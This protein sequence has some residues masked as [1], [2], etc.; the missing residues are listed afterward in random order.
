MRLGEALDRLAAMD[1]Q[2][3][4]GFSSPSA[5]EL[6]RCERG[7][8]WAGDSR[9]LA[10]RLLRKG[11]RG[12]P[13]IRGALMGGVMLWSMAEL[14]ATWA[15]PETESELIAAARGKTVRQMRAWLA[16]RR[17]A[18]RD[19]PL[20]SEDEEDFG[21]L[22]LAVGFAEVAVVEATRA[23]VEALDGELVTD[24]RLLEAM[25][26]E[27]ES[28]L[29]G[30]EGGRPRCKDEDED[31]ELQ[32][33]SAAPGRECRARE[34]ERAEARIPVVATL[35]VW[36]EEAP[37]PSTP[38]ELDAEIRRC[39]GMLARRDLEMGRLCRVLLGRRGWET[40]GYATAAQY[41]RERV[42]V[43]LSSL[44]HRCALARCADRL[45]SLGAALEGGVLGYEAARLVGR[46]A[47]PQ[48]VDA[49]VERATVRTIKHLREE[50]AAVELQ[51][52]LGE[53]GPLVP[54]D[55]GQLQEVAAFERAAL[56][57][58]VFKEVLAAKPPGRQIS[59]RAGSDRELRLRVSSGLR[60]YFCR[61]R[62]R[63]ERVAPPEASFIGFLGLAVWDAWLP[64]VRGTVGRWLGIHLRDRYRCCSPVCTRRDVT[65]H[66]LQ[67][68]SHGGGDEDENVA[69]LCSWCHLEGIHQGRLRASPPASNI[70][71]V[72]G[73]VPIMRVDGRVRRLLEGADA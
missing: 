15:T 7:V 38:R 10:S 60:A 37:L 13:G 58:E 12:L 53:V 25:L 1:G 48:T 17:G 35:G 46:V 54:P 33:G 27:G 28:A 61:L 11:G 14:L 43:S 42:G 26:A 30:L 41:A 16:T 47:A 19:E 36:E 73:R 72:I 63:F 40:L 49:W 44:R 2:A 21:V 70:G 18:D 34:E 68:R 31:G 22:R 4:L 57:G 3:E 45:P 65:A 32:D 23:V 9:R 29:L 51:E 52:R 20:E 50:V 71:W 8:R 66:H 59:V 6:E 69:S 64:A 39:C 67:F 56:G 62:A 24:E 5:Y 55:D